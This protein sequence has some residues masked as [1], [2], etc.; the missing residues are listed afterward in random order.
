MKR[1]SQVVLAISG[2]I[3]FTLV[4]C[5]E[6]Y[7]QP[8]TV[9]QAENTYT[10]NQYVSGAGYYHAPYRGWYPYTYDHYDSSRGYYRG[11]QWYT[12]PDTMPIQTS[13]P[14]AEAVG[15]AQSAHDSSVG[16]RRGGFG[17][18]SRSISS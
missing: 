9:L 15:H 13:K 6:S 10:N 1:S 12:Y 17:H 8:R 14:T 3:T 5:S 11:G 7:T 2:A 18:S 16:T 4:G